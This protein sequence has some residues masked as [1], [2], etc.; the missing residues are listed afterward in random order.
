MLSRQ[1]FADHFNSLDERLG[2]PDS[3]LWIPDDNL[4]SEW[5]VCV[6]PLGIH[7]LK[8]EYYAW[9]KSALKGRVRCYSSSPEEEQEWWGFT[10]QEDIVA[11]TL[12]W[13]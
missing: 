2:K 12:K 6:K 11:W 3:P 5:F 8:E 1:E 9:C 7:K 13:M 4:P 10:H